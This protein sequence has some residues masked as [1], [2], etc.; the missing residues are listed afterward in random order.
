MSAGEPSGHSD[1]RPKNH[2]LLDLA[3]AELTLGRA[4]F[5][6]SLL[7]YGPGASRPERPPVVTQTP[8]STAFERA[9][10]LDYVP[11]GLL[12]RA[13]LSYVKRDKAGAESDL[14]EAWEITERGPMPLYQADIYLYRAR[15]F[16]D[17]TALAGPAS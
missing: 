5:F 12:T 4:D 14:N 10:D 9:G 7:A 15:L 13:W 8:R 6:R 11:L 17:R 3:L 16:G 1:N 2:W